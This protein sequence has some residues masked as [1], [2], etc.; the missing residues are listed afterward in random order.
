MKLLISP[1]QHACGFQVSIDDSM[2][3]LHQ[4]EANAQAAMRASCK[5]T[6]AMDPRYMSKTIFEWWW[7]TKGNRDRLF[8]FA[9]PLP[10]PVDQAP[11]PAQ[12]AF[13]A[14][15]SWKEPVPSVFDVRKRAALA[16][17]IFIF[18]TSFHPQ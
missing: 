2:S 7:I 15:E 10:A 9:P 16:I 11:M 17:W 14:Q 18:S 12:P 4:F 6:M 8:N 3:M 13:E 1:I 5:E